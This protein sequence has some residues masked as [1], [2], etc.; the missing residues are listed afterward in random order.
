MR[1]FFAKIVLFGGII[2]FLAMVADFG[3]SYAYLHSKSE[4]S[5]SWNDW[6]D[7]S[8]YYD[9]IICGSSRATCSFN[10]EI[11]D[12]ILNVDSYNLGMVGCA[13]NQQIIKYNRYCQLH[14]HPKFLIWNI[15]YWTMEI[16]HYDNFQ[17]FPFFWFDRE[18]VK[19]YNQY[20][21]YAFLNKWC[22]L[23]R[24]VGYSQFINYS[25]QGNDR[26]Y[27]GYAK[28][29][30]YW[31]GD[32]IAHNVD[33]VLCVQN[34]TMILCFRQLLKEEIKL[35][36]QPILVYAPMY[37]TISECSP[38]K[39]VMHMMY[40][41]LV[42]EFN[43]PVLDYS[44]IEMCYDTTYFYNKMHVNYKGADIFTKKLAYDLRKMYFLNQE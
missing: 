40:K 21:H 37:Y 38:D 3:L 22:P 7:N 34:S 26:L 20:E 2:W 9:V 17:V 12:S 19:M 28:R 16:N 32:D 35:G 1:N 15:D 13:M 41:S 27:K 18:I 31:D 11:L 44:E 30:Y 36:V 14:G 39:E 43:I 4:R 24:Y 29:N 5:L 8:L 42:E 23:Y 33:S 10:V 6:L 25:L